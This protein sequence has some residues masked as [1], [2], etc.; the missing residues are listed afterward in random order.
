M[1]ENQMIKEMRTIELEQRICEC[2]YSYNFK[3]LWN[4]YNIVYSK[5]YAW[6][7]RLTNVICKNCGFV[8]VSPAPT[9]DCLNY[10]Y[11]DCYVPYRKQKLDYDIDS[12]IK[13]ITRNLHGTF[14]FLDIGSNK[15][16][17]FH[18]KLKELF[19]EVYTVEL[20]KNVKSDFYS[21][22][23]LPENSMDMIAHY[24][25]LEHIPYVNE[26][27]KCCY[28]ALKPS[29][30]MIIEV[31]DISLYPKDISALI[32][33][34]HVN[35]FS[36]KKLTEINNRLGFRLID[37][38]S[39]LC[40]RTFGFAAAFRKEG[41]IRL[42]TSRK[43]NEYPENLDYFKKGIQKLKEFI[44]KLDSAYLKLRL[45]SQ[46][47][48][49]SVLWGANSCLSQFLSP[50][51]LIPLNAVIVDSDPDKKN[52]SNKFSVYQPDEVAQH[53]KD[54]DLILIFTKFHSHDILRIIK[55][56]Y[57]KSFQDSEIFI[58]DI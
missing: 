25:V 41:R 30:I 19:S 49:K 21:V 2:C 39:S 13:F 20:N 1:K 47:G 58:L 18:L 33:H 9:K 57:N 5:K 45:Y 44:I 8:F 17:K 24:F 15:K 42:I 27:L 50:D 12:R 28:S 46:K 55:K 38:S 31:P 29:G 26:F 37:K 22:F 3:K 35:H 23:D 56:R 10:Y 51:K 52:F 40:S 54:S 4:N 43:I 7:F 36:L 32:L 53:I 14:S 34:E 11:S 48:K 16:T 6:E